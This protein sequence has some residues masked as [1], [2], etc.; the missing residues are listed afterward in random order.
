M[1]ARLTFRPAVAYEPGTVYA[2]LAECYADILDGALQ[3]NLRQF[4][5]EVF[6]A[7][8][9]V[10]ACAF[11]SSVDGQSVAFFSYDPRQGPEVGIIGHNGVL[12]P[13]RRRGYGTEQILEIVRRFTVRRFVRARVTTSEHP[14]FLPARSMYEKCGFRVSRRT[15]GDG[16][17]PYGIVHYERPLIG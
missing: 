1:T 13:F 7:P 8:D 6:A 17:G 11:I 14:F 2:I 15:P 4:D 12:P 9:T 5:H 3:D 10:G 16:R